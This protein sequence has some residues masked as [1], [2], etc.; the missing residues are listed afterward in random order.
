VNEPRRETRA[1]RAKVMMATP[2]ATIMVT[3]KNELTVVVPAGDA[4][5]RREIESS[6]RN[7]V[8]IM[9]LP[10]SRLEWLDDAQTTAGVILL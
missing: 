5:I 9:G 1:E 4:Q 6:F 3:T 2:G 10:A 7:T 8:A